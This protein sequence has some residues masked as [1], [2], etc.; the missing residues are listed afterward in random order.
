MQYIFNQTQNTYQD[1]AFVTKCR[2]VKLNKANPP[3]GKVRFMGE[4]KSKNNLNHR[5]RREHR[6]KAGKKVYCF[7][8]QELVMSGYNVPIAEVA[9]DRVDWQLQYRLSVACTQ[10]H[11]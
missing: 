6:G 4:V 7:W 9:K 8:V 5:G 10:A 1:A 3:Y 11:R 2:R